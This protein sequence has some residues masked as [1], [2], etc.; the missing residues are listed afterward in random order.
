MGVQYIVRFILYSAL[1]E[2]G[3]IGAAVTLLFLKTNVTLIVKRFLFFCHLALTGNHYS[4]LKK[5]KT[6]AI[7]VFTTK[8]WLEPVITLCTM[9]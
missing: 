7:V 9:P 6:A 2:I 4:G 8:E 1:G 5:V 3:K